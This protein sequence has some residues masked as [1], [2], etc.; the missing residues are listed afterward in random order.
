MSKPRHGDRY[1]EGMATRRSVLGDAHV[2]RAEAAKTEFDIPFQELITE[3]AWS[4]VWSR[5]NITRR[6]RSMITIALLAALKQD[7]E[8][9]MHIRASVNTGATRDDIREALLHVAIYAGV[10]AANHAMKIA[11]K[12]FDEIDAQAG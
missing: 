6:E 5:P 9:A 11:R 12:T 1:V 7:E 4:H 10:P 2:D 3:A 8:V